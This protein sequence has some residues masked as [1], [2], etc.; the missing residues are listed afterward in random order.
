[1]LIKVSDIPEEGLRVEFAE[2]AEAFDGL[3][4]DARPAGPVRG[5]FSLKMVGPTVY[6]KGTVE[7]VV[8][9]DCS[10]CGKPFDT[11]VEAKLSL[12]LNPVESLAGEDEK[13]LKEGDLDVGFYTGG[14]IDLTGLLAEQLVLN[15]PMKPLCSEGCRGVCQFCGQDKNENECGC[16]PPAGHPGFEGLKDLLEKM[17][18]EGAKEN[19]ESD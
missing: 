13:E 8:S 9:L 2:G 5:A 15:L 1:M 10:R 11:R 19:G 4:G 7:A 6:V 14:E 16:E 18:R 17:K 12:D 3:G